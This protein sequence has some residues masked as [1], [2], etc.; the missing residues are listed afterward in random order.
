[1]LTREDNPEHAMEKCKILTEGIVQNTAAILLSVTLIEET[2]L[3][4]E[5]DSFAA[6][7]EIAGDAKNRQNVISLQAVMLRKA[8][9]NLFLSLKD[10]NSVDKS[11]VGST[12]LHLKGILK[13]AAAAT[14]SVITEPSLVIIRR[15]YRDALVRCIISLER[16][17][18]EIFKAGRL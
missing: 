18:N 5:I 4:G 16:L 7:S 13:E 10:F 8:V 11:M 17:D 1:M 6:K 3:Q 2:F 15:E 12:L 14:N 9:L